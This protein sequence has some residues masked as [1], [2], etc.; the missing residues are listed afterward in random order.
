M[1]LCEQ[2]GLNHFLSLVESGP[3]LTFRKQRIA[4]VQILPASRVMFSLFKRLSRTKRMALSTLPGQGRVFPGPPGSSS[5]SAQKS[6]LAK[7]R[8]ELQGSADGCFMSGPSL[9]LPND[10]GFQFLSHSSGEQRCGFLHQQKSSALCL[11]PPVSSLQ[12]LK[13]GGTCQAFTSLVAS[14]PLSRILDCQHV[15]DSNPFLFPV[16]SPAQHST[17]HIV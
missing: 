12:E 1:M 2:K 4:V 13:C 14:S 8:L 16:L 9:S 3:L 11:V 6:L 7:V 10:K 17:Q 5:Q 15:V